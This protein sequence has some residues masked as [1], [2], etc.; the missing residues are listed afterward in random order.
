MSAVAPTMEGFFTE[1]LMNQWHASPHTVGAYSD[2]F[3]LLLSF[4]QDRTG[5]APYALDFC[6]LDAPVIGTF[7]DYLEHERGNSV[8]TRNSRLAAIH[9]LF[10]FAAL[11]HPEHAAL[12][13]R[14]LAIPSKRF[15]KTDVSFLEAEEVDALL[16]APDRTRWIGRRD[17]ALLATAV[18]TG[19]RVSELTGLCRRDV[20]LGKDPHIRCS[21]KGRSVA[22]RSP[23]RPSP[24]SASGSKSA[25]VNRAIRCSRPAEDVG[26][27]AT[28][29]PCSWPST[30]KSPGSGARR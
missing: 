14:V 9:S 27:A 26:S 12:I 10:R 16:R 1:R 23:L 13:Q 30:R 11:R 19:L 20:N 6:D 29:W 25:G 2:T 24:F 17:H 3:R 28:P 21:G 8:R 7:L 5:T 4:V 15:S 18:E 22:R